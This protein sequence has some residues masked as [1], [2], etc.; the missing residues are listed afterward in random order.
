MR[1]WISKIRQWAIQVLCT[2]LV[3]G[4]RGPLFASLGNT[5]SLF[6]WFDVRLYFIQRQS[7]LS[8]GATSNKDFS[9]RQNSR[10]IQKQK[11]GQTSVRKR[12]AT[13]TWDQVSKGSPGRGLPML[14]NIIQVISIALFFFLFFLL[15]KVLCIPH[16]SQSYYTS[17]A[18]FEY[19]IL[20]CLAPACQC[21][22]PHPAD[23][24]TS[25]AMVRCIQH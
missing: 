13:H 15:G 10:H 18:G 20:L 24:V 22:L 2:S 6:N 12:P 23:Q 4:A 3:W 1:R 11:H 14:C 21:V 5:Q 16:W 17:I 19:S 7:P 8:G 25:M 9:S